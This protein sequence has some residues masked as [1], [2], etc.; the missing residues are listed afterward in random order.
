[1]LVRPRKHFRQP[2][3]VVLRDLGHAHRVQIDPC[4]SCEALRLGLQ[5]RRTF[6]PRRDDQ[7]IEI[8]RFSR[9]PV[10]LCHHKP[11][12]AIQARLARRPLVEF[13]Q[14]RSPRLGNSLSQLHGEDFPPSYPSADS[15]APLPPGGFGAL[16]SA[17][18]YEGGK[19]SPCNWLRE[20]PSLG[21][22]F[23]RN[24]TSGRRARRAWIAWAG[25]W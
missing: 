6:L 25:L 8:R 18:G 1:M 11:A 4:I 3:F 2:L 9:K 16:E 22:R 24:S 13:L 17:D 23:W 12:Q 10:K 21:D 5:Q 14:K 7:H 20:F 19:S 15:N